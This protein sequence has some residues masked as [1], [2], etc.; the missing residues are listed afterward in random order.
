METNLKEFIKKTLE[1][2]NAAMPKDYVLDESIEFEVSVTTNN[3]KSGGIEIKVVSGG[4]SK[5][6]QL[7]QR[8]NFS[9]TNLK[10]K[11]QADKKVGETAIKVLAKGIKEINNLSNSLL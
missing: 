6:N 2:I 5:A 1:E 3:T 8:V 7:V 10:A 9:V 11:A 4:I